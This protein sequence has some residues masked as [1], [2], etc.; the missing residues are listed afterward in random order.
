VGDAAA[1]ASALAEVVGSAAVRAR[2]AESGRRRAA[3]FSW[4]ATAG[5]LWELYGSL[6]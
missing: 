4:D 2:L 6:L 5:A 1:L 3:D